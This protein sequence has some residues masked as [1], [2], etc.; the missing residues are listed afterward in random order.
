MLAFSTCPPIGGFIFETFTFICL[1]PEIHCK[2][3]QESV[4]PH[5]P[6]DVILSA[7][8]LLPGQTLPGSSV[9]LPDYR[10]WLQG[11][12]GFNNHINQEF[13]PGSRS[14]S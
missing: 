3:H 8:L 7:F 11:A 10:F 14:D 1:R 5:A 4:S 13:V 12:V 9:H 2:G 6:A